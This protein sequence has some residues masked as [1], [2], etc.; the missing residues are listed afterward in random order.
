MH[1]PDYPHAP[2]V[3][4]SRCCQVRNSFQ[5]NAIFT[6][7]SLLT[8]AQTQQSPS[9]VLATSSQ[10][11]SSPNPTPSTKTANTPSKLM[12]ISSG[13]VFLRRRLVLVEGSL[14]TG[15]AEIRQKTRKRRRR[16][17]VARYCLLRWSAMKRRRKLKKTRRRRNRLSSRI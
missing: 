12:G 15:K 14:N 9:A 16:A 2:R 13:K 3:L 10:Q 4:P 1:F 6:N 8:A 7:H 5:C 17:R 11:K